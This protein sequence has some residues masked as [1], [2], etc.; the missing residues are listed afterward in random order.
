MKFPNLKN[1]NFKDKKFIFPIVILIPFLFSSW[2]IYD[3]FSNS[4]DKEEATTIEQTQGISDVPLAD[5]IPIKSKT[6]ALD[7]AYQDDKD[8]TA[9][10]T[11]QERTRIV[12]DTTLYTQEELDLLA[13]LNLTQQREEAQIDQYN[14]DVK[15]RNRQLSEDISSLNQGGGGQEV[16][17]SRTTDLDKEIM[18]YQ[19]MLRGEEVLTEEQERARREEQIRTEERNKVLSEISKKETHSVEKISSNNSSGAFNTI[20]KSDKQNDYIRA[21]VDQGVTVTTGSR[22]RFRLLDDIRIQGETVPAGSQIYALVTSFSNQRV[23]ANISSIITK[24]KRVKV[25]LSIYDRDGIEGF[26]IPKSAFRDFAKEAS[27]QALQGNTLNIN[28]SS[29]SLEGMAIQAL[30][31][32]YQSATNAISSKIRE[33]KAT[34]KY[35]T[36]IYLINND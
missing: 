23:K 1:I 26:F 28:Q 4:S 30:Q 7:D 20:G 32:V 24:G 11:A 17:D 10:Q 5:S 14:E 21:M 36:T 13:S 2:M 3:L 12:S 6:Q 15:R 31:G 18:L 33:N 25:N 8:Y 22:I 35:N 34:I 9:V 16:R 27:S 29:E 19:K